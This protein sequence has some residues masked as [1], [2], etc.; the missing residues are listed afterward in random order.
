MRWAIALIVI[1]IGMLAV[2]IGADLLTDWHP[3]ELGL[4]GFVVAMGGVAIRKRAKTTPPRPEG[5]WPSRR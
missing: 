5:S 4:M 1:G 2:D 3:N